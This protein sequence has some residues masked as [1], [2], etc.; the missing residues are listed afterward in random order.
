VMRPLVV[1]AGLVLMAAAGTLA[2]SFMRSGAPAPPI[3]KAGP[4]EP[5]AERAE[6]QEGAESPARPQESRSPGARRMLRALGAAMAQ[7]SGG[8]SATVRPEGHLERMWLADR[9]R[10]MH[11]MMLLNPLRAGLSEGALGCG[12]GLQARS[13]VAFTVQVKGSGQEV[14]VSAPSFEVKAGAPLSTDVVACLEGVRR[15]WAHQ[16]LRSPAGVPLDEEFQ[17]PWVVT[18]GAAAAEEATTPGLG[19][20]PERAP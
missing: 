20:A 8:M 14:V 16:A 10:A 15:R 4:S 19:R 2:F 3:E 18:V 9:E 5:K 12:R 17:S 11:Y 6:G 13:T 1:V 7:G